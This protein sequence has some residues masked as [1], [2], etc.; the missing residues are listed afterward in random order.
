M[1]CT[2]I[3]VSPLGLMARLGPR[4]ALGRPIV[5]VF[6]TAW[7]GILPCTETSSSRRRSSARRLMMS[8]PGG[9]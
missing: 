6:P 2:L 8:T 1:S 3:L 4:V 7:S 5:P 9:W